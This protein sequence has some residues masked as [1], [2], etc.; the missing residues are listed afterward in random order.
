[1]NNFCGFKFLV[2]ERHT[3][4]THKLFFFQ[5]PFDI[6]YKCTLYTLNLK[7]L[8]D[9][10]RR[11]I[12]KYTLTITYYDEYK[13]NKIRRKNYGLYNHY[14][15][16]LVKWYWIFT[17]ISGFLLLLLYNMDTDLVNVIYL[18]AAFFHFILFIH[19]YYSI[20]GQY[21]V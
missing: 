13:R 7:Y 8:E 9:G 18:K 6:L 5:L 11:H 1:M 15:S 12:Y 21:V 19:Y 16:T 14:F 3:I 20:Q 10:H 2:N 4:W 17:Y